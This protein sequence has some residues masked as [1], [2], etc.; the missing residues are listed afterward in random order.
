MEGPDAAALRVCARALARAGV[1]EGWS[2]RPAAA[3]GY[4]LTTRLLRARR[5]P[6]PA[7]AEDRARTDREAGEELAKILAD[8][9]PLAESLAPELVADDLAPID[10]IAWNAGNVTIEGRAGGARWL[11][12]YRRLVANLTSGG[13]PHVEWKV[14]LYEETGDGPPP[15]LP[16]EG[17]LRVSLS[18]AHPGAVLRLFADLDRRDVVVAHETRASPIRGHLGGG[19]AGIVRRLAEALGASAHRVGPVDVLVPANRPPPPRDP[20]D[21]GVPGARLASVTLDR[22]AAPTHEILAEIAA[23]AHLAIDAPPLPPTDLTMRRI[24]WPVALEAI[25]AAHGCRVRRTGERRRGLECPASGSG[26]ESATDPDSDTGSDAAAT[27]APPPTPL[28]SL[29]VAALGVRASGTRWRALVADRDGKTTLVRTGTPLGLERAPAV[30]DAN[31][32]TVVLERL[33]H[34]GRKHLVPVRL[35]FSDST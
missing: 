32:V 7:N 19:W 8:R 5:D 15:A 27:P 1:V 30:V 31:G 24:P 26:T 23:V 25:A 13:H 3:G 16:D 9:A 22:G 21:S 12:A 4:R 14:D 6:R 2:L 35:P 28:R 11:D 17:A 10:E 29:R 18:G 33:D 34:A 20:D